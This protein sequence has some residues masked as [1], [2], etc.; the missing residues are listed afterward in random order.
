MPPFSPLTHAHALPLPPSSLPS[1]TPQ[2]PSLEE[3]LEVYDSP[4]E[5]D[6][7]GDKVWPPQP[8]LPPQRE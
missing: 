6:L 3:Y 1:A 5:V 2:L 7:E 4:I 8:L